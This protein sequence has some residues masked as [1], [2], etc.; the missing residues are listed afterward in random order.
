MYT[1]ATK[2]N[3]YAQTKAHLNSYTHQSDDMAHGYENMSPFEYTKT[4]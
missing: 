3:I 4:S 2:V 1:M